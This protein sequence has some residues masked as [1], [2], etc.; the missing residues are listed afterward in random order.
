MINLDEC[1]T[2]QVMPEAFRSDV[3]VQS[4]SYALQETMR[5]LMGKIDRASVYA[6]IDLLP[7]SIID[8]LA[9][10]L[11]A[12]YYDVSLPIKD[13]RE[14]VKIALPWYKKAGTVSAVRE[15]CEFRYGRSI[16]QEWFDYDDRK[17]FTFRLEMLGQN[18]L[19]VTDEIESFIKAIRSVKNTRSLLEALIFHRDMESTVYSGVAAVSWMR[20]VIVDFYVEQTEGNLTN[21]S[22]GKANETFRRQVV[23]NFGIVEKNIKQNVMSGMVLTVDRVQIITEE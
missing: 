20:Q 3:Q 2:L 11:R 9:E 23:V 13:K 10:E 1:L 14:A 22:S 16:V 6:K 21:H 4:A 8:L 17:P 18:K 15:L 19:L 7:E 5:M 12:Q